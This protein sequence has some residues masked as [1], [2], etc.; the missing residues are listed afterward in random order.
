M[1][2]VDLDSV[3]SA[4]SEA[5][6]SGPDLGY[7]LA[8]GAL[9]RAAQGK[10]A[11]QIGNTVSAG[12]DPDWKAVQQQGIALLARTR[13][14]RIAVYVARALLRNSGW[15]GFGEGLALVRGLIERYWD[16]GLHPRLDPD[17]DN[18][19]TIRLSAIRE[20]GGADALTMVRALPLV[21][22]PIFGPL[23]LRDVEIATGDMPAPEGKDPAT[24]AAI[25]GSLNDC[26]IDALRTTE[27]GVRACRDALAGIDEATLAKLGYE[28]AAGL[29]RLVGLVRRAATLV[30][31]TLARRSEVAETAA[32]AGAAEPTATANGAARSSG[33]GAMGEISSRE[34]VIKALDKICAYY[35]RHE[36]SSPIPLFMERSKRLVMMN[37]VDIVN[38]LVPDAAGQVAILK[39]R[40]EGA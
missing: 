12:T 34:E 5:E 2:F 19:P 40:T 35:K 8:F 27:A 3:L 6:P 33:G 15:A 37:F 16:N 25:E 1:P 26:P 30:G 29:E 17:D 11:Q 14:L 38:E 23:T 18:D 36:P 31:D 10:P 21:I 4:V 20:L 9:E 13:D 7:D 39:G 32:A 28:N 24:M 22:S